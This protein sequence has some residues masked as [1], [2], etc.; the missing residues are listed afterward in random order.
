[1]AH[2]GKSMAPSLIDL[3]RAA[4]Y[5]NDMTLIDTTQRKD[6]LIRVLKSRHIDVPMVDASIKIPRKKRQ[7]RPMS[8]Y[9]KEQRAGARA[10]AK[11]RVLGKKRP[12]QE[13]VPVDKPPRKSRKKLPYTEEQ[14]MEFES[15]A[16]L[17]K[18]MA[19]AKMAQTKMKRSQQPNVEAFG[20]AENAAMVFESPYTD[21]Q[22]MSPAWMAEASALDSA[23]VKMRARAKMA[24]TKMKRAF[25][26]KVTSLADARRV[27]KMALAK[28]ERSKEKRLYRENVAQFGADET[29]WVMP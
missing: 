5:Y 21:E 1:M 14:L 18:K 3:K 22:Y 8:T 20:K 26:K 4:R 28:M 19:R 11:A 29:A 25:E 16:K 27:K 12:P 6:T 17:A 7:P 23:H 2:T 13:Y 24:Q 9:T 10:R 15:V